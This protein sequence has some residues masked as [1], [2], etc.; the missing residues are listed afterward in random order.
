MGSVEFKTIKHGSSMRKLALGAWGSPKDPSVNVQIDLDVTRLIEHLKQTSGISLKQAIIK[1]FSSVLNDIPELN[2]VIIRNKFRQRLNNRI[3]IPTVFRNNQQVDLNGIW[4][5]NAHGMTLSELNTCW[6]EK[7]SNLRLGKDR[8]THRVVSIFKRLPDP[9][10]KPIIRLIDFIQYTCNISLKNF[11]LPNDPF[12][13]MTVTFLDKLNVRYANIP[14]YSFSRSAI[15][16]AIGRMYE[17]EKKKKL[18][19]TWTFDHRYFDGFEGGLGLKR[20][21][22]YLKNPHVL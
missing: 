20:I 5:D 1:I 13:S 22:Y 2:T 14:I 11:G 3:F 18:P 16:A 21:N 8:P 4:I 19:I 12:G 17:D 15:T 6:V 9:L 10:C 7:I